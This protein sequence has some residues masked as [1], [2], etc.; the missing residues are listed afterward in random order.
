M[1]QAEWM[2][3]L[4]EQEFFFLV[5]MVG[6]RDIAS[7]EDPYRGYLMQELEEEYKQVEE[8]LVAKGYLIPQE[9]GTGFNMD[10]MLGLSIAACGT[11]N[12]IS[13]QKSI[14]GTGDYDGLFYFTNPIVVERTSEE[15]HDIVL[16]PVA[17]AKLSLELIER[18]F[19]LTLKYNVG[20]AVEMKGHTWQ[21]W[22]Q[23][24][25]EV[26]YA[27]LLKADCTEEIANSILDVFE[28]GERSGS[29]SFLNRNGYSWSKESYHYAQQG[30]K[31][32]LVT[33][34][35]TDRL[36]IQPYK[37]HVIK[38]ALERFAQQFDMSEQKE[39]QNND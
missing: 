4:T 30:A 10:E 23:L 7:Y 5:Q 26:K 38:K 2:Y 36:K 27:A 20:K 11:G 33:E 17:N 32:Y 37:P 14:A 21:S 16:T 19:P 9:N 24:D 31:L 25:R 3:P 13:I 22:K 15:Q 28:K 1:E 6:I 12:V 34:P 29:I 39:E 18:I 35:S 8:Q